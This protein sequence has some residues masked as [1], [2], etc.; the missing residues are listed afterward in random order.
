MTGTTCRLVASK[1]G[2]V[3]GRDGGRLSVHDQDVSVSTIKIGAGDP[4][5]G[6]LASLEAD[7]LRSEDIG[8]FEAVGDPPY[9]VAVTEH[10][11]HLEAAAPVPEE[12][13]A[14]T[15][16]GAGL[17]HGQP[18]GLRGGMDV[19]VL[20]FAVGHLHLPAFPQAFDTQEQG[21]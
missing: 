11:D 16:L 4:P 19:A 13:V 12:P 14:H 17:Q 6:L 10:L 1:S 3:S 8:K 20:R 15:D 18:G 2:P 7:I 5:F 21:L 9:P